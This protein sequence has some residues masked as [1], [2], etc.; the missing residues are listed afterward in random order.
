LEGL[1]N[2]EVWLHPIQNTIIYNELWKGICNAQP[3]KTSDVA[4]L[5]KWDLKDEKILALIHST[6]SNKVYIH[7]ENCVDDWTKWKNSQGLV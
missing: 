7:I 5:K 6:I 3:N 1:K 4:Q 2:Y